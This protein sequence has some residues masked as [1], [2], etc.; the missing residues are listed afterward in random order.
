MR[1]CR[2]YLAPHQ[3]RPSPSRHVGAMQRIAAAPR[4]AR[5]AAAPG[6]AGIPRAPVA[7]SPKITHAPVCKPGGYGGENSMENEIHV[8]SSFRT[9]PA[10][11]YL[12][13]G[14]TVS[15][16]REFERKIRGTGLVSKTQE[17]S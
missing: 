13:P 2:A 10:A 4:V 6:G 8:V 9:G 14:T 15:K 12:V 17:L 16:L 3:A 11:T 1:A 7:A 5:M